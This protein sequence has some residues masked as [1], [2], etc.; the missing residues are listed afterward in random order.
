[1]VTRTGRRTT[2]VTIVVCCL[3]LVTGP[4]ASSRADSTT[5]RVS[6]ASDGTQGDG[7]S[8]LSTSV[9]ADGR[10]VAFTSYA[11]NL[12][13][14]DTNGTADVFVHDRTTATTTRVNVA[15]GGTQTVEPAGGGVVSGVISG[16]GRY[17]ALRS[18][19]DDLVAGDTNGLS[20]VFVH[21]R[22]TGTTTRVSLADDGSQITTSGSLLDGIS[23]DG[24]Y[25]C[26]ETAADVWVRD[27]TAGTTSPVGLSSSGARANSGTFSGSMSAD[28]RYVAFTSTATNLVPGDTN[29][30][31]DIFVRDRMAQ[32]TTRVSVASDGTQSNGE[33]ADPPTISPD[34][35]YVM[36]R[37][38]ATNLSRSGNSGI[39]IRDRTLSSTVGLDLTGVIQ[40]PSFVPL[41]ISDG[42]RYLTYRTQITEDP[43][44]PG[45]PPGRSEVFV[46]DRLNASTV[47][48]GLRGDG[49]PPTASTGSDPAGLT[50]DGRYVTYT[51]ADTQQVSGD[52]NGRSDT[53]VRDLGAPAPLATTA[54]GDF[55][56]DGWPDLISKQAST[57]QLHLN[58][59]TCLNL[60]ARTRI[61]TG[62]NAMS[63]LTR[64]GDFDQDGHEDLLAR[65]SATGALWLYP[66]TGS[67]F[68]P[69]V[70]IGRSGWNGFRQITPAG[71]LTGDH[72]PDLLAVQSATGVL[73]LYPGHGTGFGARLAVGRSGW[74]AMD[75]LTGA[76]DLTGDG[77]PDLLARSA[78]T[79]EL[80]LYP[81]RAGGGFGSRARVGTGF[82]TMRD[83]TSIGDLNRDGHNDLVA[84]QASTNRLF[85][86]PW[87]GSAYGP[88]V[89]LGAGWG[90]DERPLL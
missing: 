81:G 76:G 53:F 39:Y 45:L 5:T 11:S 51:S 32:T 8:V 29:A 10:Y 20:D 73:Y 68:R 15:T 40:G 44:D 90:T 61:G 86:Y 6:L 84:V 85:M 28:G 67:G 64:F 1:M 79:G 88:R 37:S 33:S 65:E 77:Q 21:D 43:P 63:S 75:E 31:I 24:R 9:S 50:P 34:G 38:E 57:G 26:F 27:R 72:W 7:D 69:R 12:V 89:L 54:F 14:G 16:D 13:V 83:L 70:L 25:V 3:P 71:D 18:T 19:A 60:A 36:F 82:G 2:T 58:R 74:N 47:R 52:T 22:T 41:A 42:G 35:R 66:G 62:W 46:L 30:Q 49:T 78:A 55:T 80:W 56:G 48:V 23:S 87:R 4:A 59:G 17:V